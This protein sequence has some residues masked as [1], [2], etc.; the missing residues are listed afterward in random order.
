MYDGTEV[1]SS[2]HTAVIPTCVVKAEI[3]PNTAKIL[4]KNLSSKFFLFV[5]KQYIF[6]QKVTLCSLT[7]TSKVGN[8]RLIFEELAENYCPVT[9]SVSLPP[10][11]KFVRRNI[12]EDGHTINFYRFVF[13]AQIECFCP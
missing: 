5:I 2:T 1:F 7:I 4:H 13:D 9:F 6:A 10:R 3:Q 12:S 11:I 8:P